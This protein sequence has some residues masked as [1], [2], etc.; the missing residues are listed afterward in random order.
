MRCAPLVTR[1]AHDRRML[2][3]KLLSE[4]H[5]VLGATYRRRVLLLVGGLSLIGVIEVLGIGSILPFL[6]VAGNPEVIQSNVELNRIFHALG[7]RDTQTFV[8]FLGAVSLLLVTLGNALNLAVAWAFTRFAIKQGQ[9]ISAFLLERHLAKP[10][11]YYFR[12]NIA[13]VV[14]QIFLEVRKVTSGVLQPIVTMFSRMASVIAVLGLLLYVNAPITLAVAA[15]FSC[16]YFL[17]FRFHRDTLYQLGKRAAEADTL[18]VKNALEALGAIKEV[19]TFKAEKHFL[20]LFEKTSSVLSHTE[21]AAFL[22]AHG[23]RYMIEALAFG[24]LVVVALVLALHTPGAS[25]VVPVLALF[26]FAGYRL[27]P[28]IQQVF[29]GAASIRFNRDALQRVADEFAQTDRVEVR[30]HEDSASM[31]SVWKQIELCDVGV[32]FEGRSA[33][34]LNGVRLSICRGMSVGV[35]GKTG[36]GKSTLID[37]LAGLIQPTSGSVRVDGVML[38]DMRARWLDCIGYVPQ[39]P[40][41]LDATVAE[42]IA[43]GV[44]LADV[45][46]PRVRVAAEH[47][48]IADFV[49]RG[50]PDGYATRIGDSGVRLSGGQR[51]RLAI[52][53]ALYRRPGLLL[54]DEATSAVDEETEAEI[55]RRLHASE[56]RTIVLVTHR[57]KTLRICDQVLLFDN[58]RLAECGTYDAL[59]QSSGLFS[60]MTTERVHDETV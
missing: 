13:D 54:L 19:K 6:A 51:Q 15:F 37:L 50:L 48:C 29:T 24:A 16:L 8:V 55:L 56:D 10:Y 31:P 46:M 49:E 4:I 18:R 32:C 47:A 57:I 2:V 35:M 40:H 52:A 21:S 12:H 38:S 20:D 58:G 11:E 60:S 44:A 28:A 5:C 53:R 43:F 27:L 59:R 45:D 23:P 30:E 1:P 14:T 34:G 25:N 26:G 36:A 39:S 3:R 7:F 41:F 33:P 42:N 9:R 17:L 22:A